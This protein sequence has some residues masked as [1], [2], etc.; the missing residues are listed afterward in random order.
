M[1][2]LL[3]RSKFLILKRINP[4]YPMGK[5][6]LLYFKGIPHAPFSFQTGLFFFSRMGGDQHGC[7]SNDTP[8]GLPIPTSTSA[9]GERVVGTRLCADDMISVRPVTDRSFLS[10]A[11]N[12][13]NVHVCPSSHNILPVMVRMKPGIYRPGLT[14]H[15]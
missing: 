13:G 9:G 2:S 14:C 6:L 10:T 15:L 4:L 3:P 7:C 8:M 11:C 5:V 1:S 12:L